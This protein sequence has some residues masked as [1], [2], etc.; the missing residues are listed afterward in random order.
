LNDPVAYE[1]YIGKMRSI[2]E[3]NKVYQKNFSQS[4]NT[5]SD[6]ANFI[7][8]DANGMKFGQIIQLNNTLRQLLGWTEDQVKSNRIENF[9]PTL[10][11][12]KHPQFMGR[13]N[14]T[15]QSFIINN[16]VTMF[17]KKANGYVIPVELYI[18][19]HYSI[20]YQYTYL[21]II[22]PF[23]EMAPFSN[24]IKHNVN[25]LLFLIVDNDL[26]GRITEFSESCRKLLSVFGFNPE[27]E[28]NGVAKNIQDVMLEF[29]FLDFKKSR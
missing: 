17:I 26:D 12:E 27:L 7:I 24:G 1:L 29:D 28:Q 15:G 6:L 4:G 14:K 2:L 21:A 23:Y 8:V 16:K 19:F 18:K 20:D 25:H 22:K 9:M 3:I 10:I 13:Y 11:K 5:N